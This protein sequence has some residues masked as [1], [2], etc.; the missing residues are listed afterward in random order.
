ME[1][2]RRFKSRAGEDAG[3][4]KLV[5]ERGNYV[6]LWDPSVLG[7]YPIIIDS[8]SPYVFRVEFKEKH[9]GCD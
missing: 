9:L 2:Y 4:F 6:W 5:K 3:V 7:D 8:L 1:I